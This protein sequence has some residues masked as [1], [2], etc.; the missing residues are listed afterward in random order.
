MSRIA[1]R[2]PRKT[3]KYNAYDILELWFHGN[4]NNAHTP[5]TVYLAGAATK[6][7]SP[8]ASIC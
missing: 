7:S 1:A 3:G 6:S 2:E 4:T 8:T 5:A